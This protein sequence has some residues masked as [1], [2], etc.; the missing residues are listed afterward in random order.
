MSYDVSAV[1]TLSAPASVQTM[2]GASPAWPARQKMTALY[3]QIDTQSTGSISA[4]QFHAAFAEGNPPAGF[5]HMGATAVLAKLDPR[6]T[7]TVSR[8]DFIDTM[9]ALSASVR[10]AGNGA[11]L[12]ATSNAT[13]GSGTGAVINT[14]A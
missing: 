5:R 12:A 6:S 7:G 2:T 11:A 14:T 13:S 4:A 3:N 8:A 9:S 10:A 1:S